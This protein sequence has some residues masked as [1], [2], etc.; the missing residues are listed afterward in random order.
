MKTPINNIKLAFVGVLLGA[1]LASCS[2][3]QTVPNTPT[4]STINGG[5][6]DKWWDN[7]LDIQLDLA[8]VGSAPMLGNRSAARTSAEVNARAQMAAM[9]EAKMQQLVEDWAQQAGDL[10]IPESISS[11][12]NNEQFTRQLVDATI[13]GATPIKYESYEGTQYVLMVIKDVQ[14]FYDN[15]AKAFDSKAIQNEA[16]WT[17]EVRKEGARARFA[18]TL[19]KDKMETMARQDARK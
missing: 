13:Y 2:S 19:E 4:T 6:V 3:P 12:I 7:V 18:E 14:Q 11:M 5:V 1:G 10:Q 17:S 8:V 15:A 9:K 16:F